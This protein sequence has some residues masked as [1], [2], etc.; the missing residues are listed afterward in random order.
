MKDS[1]SVTLYIRQTQLFRSECAPTFD[2][3]NVHC[4]QCATGADVHLLSLS[5]NLKLV[6]EIY[7]IMK[8]QVNG[9]LRSEKLS[10]SV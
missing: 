5:N 1:N 2:M 10:S 4:D 7:G 9:R 3:A 6:Y 8:T